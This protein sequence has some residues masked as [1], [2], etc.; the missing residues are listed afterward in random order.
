MAGDPAQPSLSAARLAGAALCVGALTVAVYAPVRDFPFLGWDDG[1]Y[2]AEN[3]NLREP[4][5]VASIVRAFAAPYESNW[6]PL[7]WISLHL[8]AAL[9]GIRPAVY[10]LENAA[11]HL[12]ASLVL[13][14]AFARATGR[15]AASAFVAGVFA[16][17]PLHV[18]SVAWIAQRK[19][20]LS[21]FFF[22]LT[23]AAHFAHAA[24]PAA[25]GSGAA[26][27]RDAARSRHR[28]PGHRSAP[29]W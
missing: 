20:C 16:L 12:A 4:F 10:H 27:H 29:G 6:I 11:L 24:R 22:A 18:E 9:F 21:G 15:V 25:T 8:D 23:I 3:P 28:D 7:T 19:D 17:H 14:L 13:L 5:G 1:V 2:V 26:R